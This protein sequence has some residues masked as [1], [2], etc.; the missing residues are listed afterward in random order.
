MSNQEIKVYIKDRNLFVSVPGQ[1]DYKSTAVGNDRFKP[2]SL[3]GYMF[4][5][6]V[7]NNGEVI[8]LY[9]AQPNGTFKAERK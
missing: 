4:S 6:D 1:P 3:P 9:F 7:D 5:F 2:D 8:A